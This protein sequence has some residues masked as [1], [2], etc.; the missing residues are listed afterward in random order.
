MCTTNFHAYILIDHLRESKKNSNTKMKISS[1]ADDAKQVDRTVTM[2][3]SVESDISSTYQGMY[4]RTY[5]V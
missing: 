4:M 2:P 5:M 3:N 1:S